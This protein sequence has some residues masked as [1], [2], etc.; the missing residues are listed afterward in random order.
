MYKNA[1]TKES[2]NAS[3]ALPEPSMLGVDHARTMFNL[4][5]TLAEMT[6]DTEAIAGLDHE[7]LEMFSDVISDTAARL[8]ENYESTLKL[9]RVWQVMLDKEPYEKL[10]IILEDEA[11]NLSEILTGARKALKKFE[12]T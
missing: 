4:E 6:S 5:P 7:W 2:A 3:M 9:E 1:A 10:G 11:R 8:R 12:K